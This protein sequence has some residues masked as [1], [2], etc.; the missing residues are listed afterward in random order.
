MRLH[1]F[2]VTHCTPFPFKEEYSPLPFKEQNSSKYFNPYYQQAR[3]KA[4]AAGESV[5][6][7]SQERQMWCE[8]FAAAIAVRNRRMLDRTRDANS[9]AA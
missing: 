5:H 1:P 3:A 6:A 4:K 2:T 7:V 9:I 8:R